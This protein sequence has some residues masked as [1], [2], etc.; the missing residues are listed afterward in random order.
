MVY[1]I[2]GAWQI[3]PE[4]ISMFRVVGQKTSENIFA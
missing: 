2:A 3:F 4:K 1:G